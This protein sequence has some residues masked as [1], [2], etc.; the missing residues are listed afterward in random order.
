MRA[1]HK[2]RYPVHRRFLYWTVNRVDSSDQ[3]QKFSVSNRNSLRGQVTIMAH[4]STF[5]NFWGS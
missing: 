2:E 4:D 1:A 3:K 5:R